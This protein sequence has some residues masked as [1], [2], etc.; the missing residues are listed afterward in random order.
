MS[1]EPNAAR[2]AWLLAPPDPYEV[3]I[4]VEAGEVSEA[5]RDALDA[6]MHGLFADDVEG[7]LV[8]CPSLA[9]CSSY[10]CIPYKKCTVLT[11]KQC[12]VDMTCRIAP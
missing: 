7:R 4:H 8:E 3:S 11:G 5:V 10:Q 2:P 12:L 1:D 6:F 9:Q